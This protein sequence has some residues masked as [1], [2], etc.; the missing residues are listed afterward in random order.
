MLTSGFN[1]LCYA[2][3]LQKFRAAKW[4]ASLRRKWHRLYKHS[5]IDIGLLRSVDY[6]HGSGMDI[7]VSDETADVVDVVYVNM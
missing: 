7:I 2:S 1:N 5:A 3:Q 4:T 6:E